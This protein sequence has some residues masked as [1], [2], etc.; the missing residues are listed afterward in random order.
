MKNIR[1]ILIYL[2]LSTFAGG[3]LLNS[4]FKHYDN[5]LPNIIEIIEYEPKSISRVY[6]R[7][8][9]LLGV[10]YDEK[11]E[12]TPISKIPNIVQF[13]FIS[14]EDKNFYQHSGYDIFGLICELFTINLPS[15]L[16]FL[17]LRKIRLT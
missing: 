3:L 2:S 1:K 7:N 11:R 5:G 13:A 12:F 14:A 10:F 8:D 9:L 16:Q 6:D 4:I 17:V 15:F